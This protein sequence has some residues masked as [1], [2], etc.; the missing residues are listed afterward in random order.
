MPTIEPTS[1]ITV[2]LAKPTLHKPVP[3]GARV[4]IPRHYLGKEATGTVWGI[5]MVHVVFVYIVILDDPYFGEHGE[6]RAVTCTGPELESEDGK[7][8]WRLDR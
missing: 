5:S 1:Q 3:M 6:T 7:T 4:R 8:N 2:P